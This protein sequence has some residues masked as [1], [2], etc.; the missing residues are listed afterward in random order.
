NIAT[1]GTGRRLHIVDIFGGPWIDRPVVAGLQ[2]ASSRL[3]SGPHDCPDGQTLNATAADPGD[4]RFGFSPE[5]T[6]GTTALSAPVF[7]AT[8]FPASS[9][10][11][12]L[13]RQFF[14]VVAVDLGLH[15]RGN[16]TAESIDGVSGADEA[17]VLEPAPIVSDGNTI[18]LLVDGQGTTG[19]VSEV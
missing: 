11:P 1:L 4:L 10:A 5:G 16:R 7:P 3:G 8:V 6:L 17:S 19:A 18:D 9:S 13:E 15:L 14:R 12:V 2:L